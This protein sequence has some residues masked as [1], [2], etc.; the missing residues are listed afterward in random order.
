M[1][2]P[3]EPKVFED[4]PKVGTFVPNDGSPRSSTLCYLV[5]LVGTLSDILLCPSESLPPI[6]KSTAH[7]K[8]TPTLENFT[9]PAE[10]HSLIKKSTTP[11]ESQHAQEKLNLPIRKHD[12][13]FHLKEQSSRPYSTPFYRETVMDFFLQFLG[14][15]I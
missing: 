2:Q 14:T 4:F 6:R 9:L 15:K 13:K 3:S 8:V 11:S 12:Y 10:V 5:E 1:V 7:Q